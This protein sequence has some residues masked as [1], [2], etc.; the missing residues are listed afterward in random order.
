[1]VGQLAKVCS[2]IDGITNVDNHLDTVKEVIEDTMDMKVLL[3]ELRVK[4]I[5]RIEHL[6]NPQ[7]VSL[8]LLSLDSENSGKLCISYCS[9][10]FM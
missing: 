6:S 2:I 8:R 1:M 5:S 9:A 7:L 10:G 3:Q 4:I